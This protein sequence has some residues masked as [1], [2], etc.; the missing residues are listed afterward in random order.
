M[1]F[2]GQDDI[3]LFCCGRQPFQQIWLDIMY[4]ADDC[5]AQAV[6]VDN[7]AGY[8]FSSLVGC[9][10][11][12][13]IFIPIKKH[14]QADGGELVFLHPAMPLFEEI[15][16]DIWVTMDHL[17]ANDLDPAHIDP[18]TSGQYFFQGHFVMEVFF[19]K[20]VQ[21]YTPLN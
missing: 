17:I 3:V 12:A 21:G 7:V 5:A 20:A 18:G 8:G 6:G 16:R 1:D 4:H 15:F 14:I 9:H 13:G 2:Q 11:P 10:N 19:L